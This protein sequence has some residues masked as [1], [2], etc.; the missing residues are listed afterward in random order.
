MI[1]RQHLT[2]FLII[3]VGI[4]SHSLYGA[5]KRFPKFKHIEREAIKETTDTIAVEDIIAGI[6]PDSTFM[7][8]DIIWAYEECA[9]IFLGPHVFSGYRNYTSQKFTVPN[10]DAIIAESMNP[11]T[12]V[13]IPNPISGRLK[14]AFRKSAL[15]NEIIYRYMTQHPEEVEYASWNFPKPPALPDFDKRYNQLFQRFEIPVIADNTIEGPERDRINWLH[16]FNVGVQFSQA[17]VSS[18]W[19]QG[20]NNYI[21]LLFNFN[22][23]VDLNTNYYPNLLFQSALSYRLAI[24]SNPSENLHR[25][26]LTQD[27]FQYNLKTG[28]KAFDH[29]FYSFTMQFRTPFFNT[30]PA[31]SEDRT[32]A[33]L[34]PGSLTLGL[35]MTFNKE[36]KKKTWKFSASIAPISYNL[37]MCMAKDVDHAQFSIPADRSTTSEIGS[38]LEANMTWKLSDNITWTS[39]MFLFTDYNY[40]LADWENTFNFAISRFFSTQLYLHPRFDSSSE[41][42]T[43]KWHYWMLKEILSIGISYTFSSKG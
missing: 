42:N 40:F 25:Y 33:F 17:Y 6:S 36:N 43:S 16:Y 4:L 10:A 1:R 32:A 11:R 22:W 19:Y 26:S 38:N 14:A 12:S 23:N 8:P 3:A 39:R 15:S 13:R 34:S 7:D 20:G 41:F 29:W 27:N 37:K 2:L 9:P 21:A 31:N 18:N 30:Y 28:I 5:P 24:N 35:G